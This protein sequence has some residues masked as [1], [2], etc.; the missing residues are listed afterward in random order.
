MEQIW[1]NFETFRK[2]SNGFKWY[3]FDTIWNNFDNPKPSKVPLGRREAAPP[4]YFAK[5]GLSKLLQMVLIP[6][7]T[8]WD[9]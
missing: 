4:G 9:I 5:F 1:N 8:I 3:Q 2:V 6:F 7:K